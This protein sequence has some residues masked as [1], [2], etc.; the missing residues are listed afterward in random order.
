MQDVRGKYLP[1]I[2][3]WIKTSALVQDFLIVECHV[4]ERHDAQRPSITTAT[5]ISESSHSLG[6]A[7]ISKVKV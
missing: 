2:E 7:R 1:V 5:T 3:T 6:T 4:E